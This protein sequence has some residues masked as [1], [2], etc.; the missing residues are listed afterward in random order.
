MGYDGLMKTEVPWLTAQQERVWRQW[1]T[2]STRLPATLHRDLRAD[3]GMS[4]PD[5]EVLVHLTDDAH[6][7]VRIAELADAI[8][9]ERSRL[10]HHLTRMEKR[11]LIR[12][13][14][15]AE[16]GRGAFVGVTDQGRAAIEKAAPGHARIVRRLVFDHLDEAELAALERL[17]SGVL[18]RIDRE[19]GVAD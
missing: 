13:E 1:Q 15:C 2:M 11:G 12:R 14:E 16:D 8:R 5:F 4:L 9:W 7:R 6:G 18:E 17:T 3:A 10:S 19:E